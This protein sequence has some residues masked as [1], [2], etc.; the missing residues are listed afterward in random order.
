MATKTKPTARKKK[1]AKSTADT[2][3]KSAEWASF[4]LAMIDEL[5]YSA[6]RIHTALKNPKHPLNA[7]LDGRYIAD[8]LDALGDASSHAI[9]MQP[10]PPCAVDVPNPIEGFD[11]DQ[12]DE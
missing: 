5:Y 12:D 1:P 8:L 6:K 2:Y 11:D 7:N 3:A 4:T 9:A 10:V